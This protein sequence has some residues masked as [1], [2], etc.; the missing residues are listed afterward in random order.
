MAD[1]IRD[2]LGDSPGASGLE[3]ASGLE[4]DPVFN[5]EPI[6]S[7]SPQ[8]RSWW[9]VPPPLQLVS[10]ESTKGW[11]LGI[12]VGTTGLSAV[13]LN[14]ITEQVYPLYWAT[15]TSETMPPNES[16]GRRFR[17][18]IVVSLMSEFVP[19]KGGGQPPVLQPQSDR[20]GIAV[21]VHEMPDMSQE[22]FP[23]DF[24]IQQLKPY[25]RVGI[26][27]WSEQTN[28]WEPILQW[29]EQ[30]T[31]PLVWL[32]KAFQALLRTFKQ[33]SRST[34]GILTCGALGLEEQALQNA[35][36]QLSGV[37]VGYPA[38]WSDTYSFNLRESI[39]AAGL[40]AQPEQIFFVE[41]TI[42]TLLSV[43]RRQGSNPG[44]PSALEQPA[45]RPTP[46]PEQSI[47][48]QNAD[49][50]GY[51]LVLNA[52]A[53]MTELALVNLPAEL[54]TLT[55]ADITYRSL[56]FAGNAIDQDIVCQLLYPLLQQPQP[57]DTRQLD[58]IDLSLRAVD[59][60]AVRLDTLTLPTVG[61]PDLPNRYRLQQRLFASQ[62]GQTLLEAACFLKRTLQQQSYLT[63]Q[64]G[65]RIWVILR[66]DLGTKVLLPYI[67]R[68]NRELNAVLK[69]TGVT[70]PEVNQVICTGGTA[71]M[72]G[73]ARWLRQKLPNA[74]IIQDT[75]T[76][77]SSPQEN[78]MFSCSRVAYGLAVLPLY[79]RLL[80]VSRHQFNDYFLLLALLRNVPKHPATFKAI[81]GCLEQS[82]IQ[83]AG[84]QSH[85][86]AL[87]EGHLPP[88]LVPSERDM[89]LFTAAS[90]Q[91]PSYQVVQ[92]PLFQKRGDRYYLNPH[93]HKQLQHFL[94]T[95]LSHTHQTLMTPYAPMATDKYR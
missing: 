41:D 82:G 54:D 90:L 77:P 46:P 29:S 27:Y 65:D 72:G 95:I 66:Q 75:Y 61:E 55:H 26:P 37:V 4:L 16:Q 15:S 73:I 80:D 89:S 93:Q 83:T 71:S 92:A 62:S 25:L 28:Q 2:L 84:C 50:Q 74:V 68:L 22:E 39:L 33:P 32:L 91:H 86:L 69:Q 34:K 14:P 31:L 20:L 70:P 21:P 47:I 19:E 24:F 6:A 44:Q 5:P 78:C 7:T 38:N 88:G 18:P 87:L 64:L 94:D 40:V 36:H 48:L 8:N 10:D 85:I 79:P 59:L 45:F 51:T 13:L 3:E 81:L 12:D 49:W 35:L 23:A 52:G 76:R 42:A 67:Q 43:L 30:Q 1:L 60:D 56:P 53:S 63:L 11:I 58:R 9:S 17:L 57:V